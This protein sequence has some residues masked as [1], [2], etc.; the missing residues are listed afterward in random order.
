MNEQLK[1]Q[2]KSAFLNP[3]EIQVFSWTILGNVCQ[4]M[5]TIPQEI[6]PMGCEWFCDNATVLESIAEPYQVYF[7]T[8]SSEQSECT[9]ELIHFVSNTDII[10]EDIEIPFEITPHARD[11]LKLLRNT[12]QLLLKAYNKVA[13]DV[14]NIEEL[15][16]LQS[17]AKKLT[18]IAISLCIPTCITEELILEKLERFDTIYRELKKCL[19]FCKPTGEW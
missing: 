11:Y 5:N 9:N 2:I 14:L 17:S 1:K 10:V 18:S 13:T 15:K 12:V 6:I 7:A 8:V 3:N 4:K 16:F 19:L